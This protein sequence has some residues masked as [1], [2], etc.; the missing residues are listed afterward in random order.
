MKSKLWLIILITILL[1][2]LLCNTA[3]ADNIGS[4]QCGDDAY[5]TLDDNGTLTITGTGPMRDYDA[6]TVPWDDNRESIENIIIQDGITRIGDWAFSGCVNLSDIMIPQSLT[7]IGESA[8]SSCENLTIVTLPSG[9]ISVG[10]S[11]F[12]GCSSLT[13]IDVDAR[14]IVYSSADGVLFNKEQTELICYPVG[15]TDSSYSIPS[16]VTNV[17]NGA[18]AYCDNLTSVTVPSSLRGIGDLTFAFCNSLTSISIPSSLSDIGDRAFTGCSSLTGIYVDQGNQFYTDVNGVLFNKEKTELICYPIGKPETCYAIPSGVTSIGEHSFRYCNN[19]S[20]ITIPEGVTSIGKRAFYYCSNLSSIVIPEGVTS[21][22]ESS[23]AACG[24]LEDITIPSSISTIGS[25]AFRFCW[26]LTNVVYPG[27]DE[28]WAAI[29]IGTGNE[30]LTVIRNVRWELNDGI[31]VINGTGPMKDYDPVTTAPWYDSRE[32][33][34]S[35]IIQDGI[36]HIGDFAFWDCDNLLDVTISQSVTGIGYEAFANCD[37]LRSIA[38]PINITVIDLYAFVSCNSLVNIYYAGTDEQWEAIDIEE[39]NECL[40]KAYYQNIKW[41][42]KDG[43]LNIFGNGPMNDYSWGKAPWYSSR[44]S[45]ESVIIQDGITSIGD[46]AFYCCNNLSDIT[47]PQSVTRIGIGAFYDCNNLTN[48]LVSSN[49]TNIEKKAFAHCDN[50]TNICVISENQCYSDINGVLF[51]SDKTELLCYPCG[52]PDTSYLIPSSVTSI[53]DYAFNGC[54][55]LNDIIIPE[56]VT[57]IGEMSFADCYN[58]VNITIPSSMMIIGQSA[59]VS[60]NNLINVVYSGTNEQWAAISIGYGNEDLTA[61]LCIQWELNDGILT[62]SGTGPMKN[63]S[64][65]SAPWYS[66]RENIESVIIQDGITSIGDCAFCGCDNLSDITIPQSITMIGFYAFS[67]CYNLTSITIPSN[68]EYIGYN[69]FAFSPNLM[70][71][72]VDFGNAVY[73]SIEGVLFNK[74]RTQLIWYPCGKNESS[75]SIPSSVTIICEA[76]FSECINLKS[77][78]VPSN[79][80]EI[81]FEAFRDCTHLES[82]SIS[83]GV[84]IIGYQAFAYCTSLTSITIPSSVTSIGEYAFDDCKNLTNISIASDNPVYADVNGVLFN[85][86]QTELIHYP[87][88]KPEDS[89]LIPS[90]VTSIEDKAFI[91]CANLNSITI[92]EGVTSIGRFSFE[93]CNNLESVTIPLSLE[94][95]DNYAFHDCIRLTNVAYSGTNEQ[96]AMIDIKEGNESLTRAYQSIRWE[97]D[98]WTLIISGSGPMEDYSRETAPWFSDRGSIDSIIIS[99]G[100]TSIGDYAFYECYNLAEII[101]PTSVT[102]MGNSAFSHCYNLTNITIPSYVSSIGDEVFFNCPELTDINVESDNSAYT[103]IDG[104]LF[105]K[106]QTQLICYPCGKTGSIYSIPS[107]VTSIGYRAFALCNNITSIVIPS[108]VENIDDEAF[109]G[110]SHLNEISISE[111]LKTIGKS[112]FGYCDSLTSITI[113]SSV[114]EIGKYAFDGCDSLAMI[115]VALDNQIFTDINGALL[116]KDKTELIFYPNGKTENSYLIPSS[117]TSIA[118]FAFDRCGNLNSIIIPEGVTE[119]GGW[120]FERC[121]NLVSISIPLSLASIGDY[122]FGDCSA[123]TDVDYPGTYAQWTEIDI[124]D[125]NECLTRAYQKIQWELNNGTLIISGNGSMPDYNIED[126]PWYN[127]RERIESVIL[128]DGITSI[129]SFAFYDCANISDIQIPTSV[130]RIGFGSFSGCANLTSITVPSSV[131]TIE[132]QAFSFCNKLTDIN[133][134]PGNPVY[135]SENGVLFNKEKTELIYYPY[136]KTDTSYFIPAGVKTIGS[137]AFMDNFHLMNITIPT[138]VTTI[139]MQAFLGSRAMTSITIPESVASIGDRAFASCFQLTGIY[140]A[141]EN[142]MYSDVNGV[143]FNKNQSEL[144]SYAIGKTENSYTIPSSV[145]SIA[146]AAFENCC[147]ITSIT[148]PSTVTSI[149]EEAFEFCS[150]LSSITIPE[151]I[152]SIE[153]GTFYGCTNLTNISIPSSLTYIGII[154]FGNCLALTNVDY[155]GTNAQWAAIEIKEGNECLIRA[156]QGINYLESAHPYSNNMDETWTYT[157]PVETDYLKVTFSNDTETESN[158]DFIY[159][160]DITNMPV[161]YTGSEL[162]GKDI[163][164]RGQ[165]FTIR[166]TSDGS[167]TS[168]GFAITSVEAVSETEY[169]NTTIEEGVCGENAGWELKCNGVLII[170]GSGPMQDYTLDTQ[171]W[172]NIK[173]S[174]ENVIIQDGITSIGNAAFIFCSNLTNVMIPTSV[175]SI[176]NSAFEQCT[177]LCSMQIPEGVKSIGNWAYQNCDSLTSITIPSSVTNIG[178]NAFSFC[179]SLINI[180]V[181]SESQNYAD[182]NGVLFNQ[183]KTELMRYPGGKSATNYLIP[184]SVTSIGDYAFNGCDNLS[185]ITIPEGVISI[186]NMSFANCNNLENVTIPSSVMNVDPS[187][188]MYCFRLSS[189]IILNRDTYFGT[190]AINAGLSDN[191]TVSGWDNSTTED[192]VR[193]NSTYSF[194]PLN[195]RTLMLP[196]ALTEIDND[197]FT[198]I[199]SMFVVIPK[200]ITEI[201]GNPFAGSSVKYICGYPGS[202]AQS[203]ADNNGY[204]FIPVDDEWM[205]AY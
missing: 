155:E 188:F 31:L 56:G 13:N 127:S 9:L 26:A 193:T 86:D 103:S 83:E 88:G 70:N 11:A 186:G 71:I 32:S 198:G 80:E 128:R 130:S 87:A 93:Y 168:Y 104:V 153:D 101:I 146:R 203:F 171:P 183:D 139:E 135:A 199:A 173:D 53:D 38:I 191:F 77:I 152:F 51:N 19:L 107:S 187:D 46:Y 96:W 114:T 60:C 200:N 175:V 68:V 14:N 180:Y 89:Y 120:S 189:L 148:I 84:K 185:N 147:N 169:E 52:K 123:L 40:T 159:L 133:I 24:N 177:G 44:E 141:P 7:S 136:G 150:N 174:I 122:A 98:N 5:W 154:A 112:A 166:L 95:I 129:G 65:G 41:E 142:Q 28:Q 109:W 192:S 23:F 57:N 176:G 113:P 118:D 66:N 115:C 4:G 29:D 121:E 184:S 34:E 48:I 170:S 137:D 116:N 22:G 85:K 156:Y 201:V 82:I 202:A 97:L 100:I 27:T 75:F 1:G 165:S 73:C 117:V 42:L 179:D 62:I 92:P 205:A 45:I 37:N 138:S 124:G 164:L 105:N 61:C 16:S 91:R 197:A 94:S 47:I 18:F 167:V 78:T 33:I 110:C 2:L 59:F 132:N 204:S 131:T 69:A 49:I 163:Y 151:G 64:W 162:A 194:E 63:Y 149:G 172:Y 196:S 134:A 140:V 99:D 21:I 158:Y 145:T 125:G 161:R 39:G 6:F 79:V 190:C 8:F 50:M 182:V 90:G 119:I 10:E 160:T 144:I 43:I 195:N 108:S 25:Q 74:D 55:N 20:S 30:S 35:V 72:N 76:A 157:H 3:A 17:G 54:G 143:L 67:G 12:S 178:E 106:D 181:T 15:K 111:G 81:G 102:R 58:L 126:V 36:T